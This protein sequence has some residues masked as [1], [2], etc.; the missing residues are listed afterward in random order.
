MDSQSAHF[1]KSPLDMSGYKKLVKNL[2]MSVCNLIPRLTSTIASLKEFKKNLSDIVL[3]I[4]YGDQTVLVQKHSKPGLIVMS[5]RKYENFR[6]PRK[7][8]NSQAEWDTLFKRID[9]IKAGMSE[10]YNEEL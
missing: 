6:D 2:A 9:T 3:R 1:W 7:R 8:F 10:K 4:M 5:E